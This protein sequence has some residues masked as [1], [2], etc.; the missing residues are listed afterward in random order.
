MNLLY[1]F[2]S[3]EKVR[4]V[5]VESV[6]MELSVVIDAILNHLFKGKEPSCTLELIGV[7]H[8]KL[9]SN[10][11]VPYVFKRTYRNKFTNK[12]KKKVKEIKKRKRR[13]KSPPERKRRWRSR[14]P[15]RNYVCR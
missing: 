15:N 9:K 14:S 4:S 7:Y 11:S 10:N 1:R 6:D 8:E 12:P 13:W 5:K 3:S 2:E